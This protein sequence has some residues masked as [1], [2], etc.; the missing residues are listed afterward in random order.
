M[1]IYKKYN[2]LCL[3]F[4]NC[5][6][7]TLNFIRPVL[8]KYSNTS[9]ILILYSTR[10][11]IFTSILYSTRVLNSQYFTQ[12]WNFLTPNPEKTLP[13]IVLNYGTFL[14]FPCVNV[15]MKYIHVGTIHSLIL[16]RVMEWLQRVECAHTQ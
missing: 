11:P 1:Y 8:K 3:L 14:H 6:F 10:V 7:I 4:Y 9:E 5:T 16:T 15:N 2:F 13:T 12:H